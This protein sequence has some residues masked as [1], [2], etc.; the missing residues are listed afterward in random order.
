[1]GLFS[2][3]QRRKK[4]AVVKSR[5]MFRPKKIPLTVKDAKQAYKRK[6]S[7]N[8]NLWSVWKSEIHQIQNSAGVIRRRK[9]AKSRRDEK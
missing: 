8:V 3:R 6:K 1:V 2:P 4:R 5:K 7:V 9:S